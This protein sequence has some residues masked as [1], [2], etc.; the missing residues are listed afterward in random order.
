M[1]AGIGYQSP[2]IARERIGP[3]A[4]AVEKPGV[5][6]TG[7]ASGLAAIQYR[8]RPAALLQVQRS[9]Y[10]DY[11]RSQYDDIKVPLHGS[12]FSLG[13]SSP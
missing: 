1:V 12:P 6:K 11:A 8:D 7:L 2:P 4:L 10:A 9:G 3:A 5:S 13:K